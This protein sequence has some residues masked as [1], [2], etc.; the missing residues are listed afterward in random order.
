[1]LY[2]ITTDTVGVYSCDDG[3]IIS[4]TKCL[5]NDFLKAVKKYTCS[6][7]Y[8]LNDGKCEKYEVITAKVHM[9]KK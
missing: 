4:G 9:M 5:K 7:A 8:T 6:K 1:M 2:T 3:F